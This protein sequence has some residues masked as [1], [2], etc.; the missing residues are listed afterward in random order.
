MIQTYDVEQTPTKFNHSIPGYDVT[1][2]NVDGVAFCYG[3]DT[4]GVW[5]TWRMDSGHHAYP[6]IREFN[7]KGSA[8]NDVADRV[9]FYR[10]MLRPAS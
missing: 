4:R 10:L 6:T 3:Q 7:N 2:M 5:M 1:R 9:R 8:R